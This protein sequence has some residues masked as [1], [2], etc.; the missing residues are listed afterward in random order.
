M[1]PGKFCCSSFGLPYLGKPMLWLRSKIFG[2]GRKI[3]AR[4]SASVSRPRFSISFCSAAAQ[5]GKIQGAAIWL[6][7]FLRERA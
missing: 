5:P 2:Y 7:C 4:D 1:F 6:I 3:A